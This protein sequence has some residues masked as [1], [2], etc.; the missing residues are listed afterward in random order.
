MNTR[1]K[2]H[3]DNHV[4]VQLGLIHKVKVRTSR[5][6]I[7]MIDHLGVK[8]QSGSEFRIL[9][10]CN[11]EQKST[12]ELL[13]S[14]KN[15]PE[16][17]S[18]LVQSCICKIGFLDSKIFGSFL[19]SNSADWMFH[20]ELNLGICFYLPSFSAAFNLWHWWFNQESFLKI[21]PVRELL[22]WAMQNDGTLTSGTLSASHLA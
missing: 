20:S 15:Y 10:C 8:T 7:Q 14:P 18:E 9:C 3:Q 6:L 2:N 11:W 5:T 1:P 19:L 12:P 4:L 22:L 21:Q 16:I 17:K 13:I